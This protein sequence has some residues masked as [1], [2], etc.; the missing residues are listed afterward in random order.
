MLVCSWGRE[1]NTLLTS[2]LLNS[3]MDCVTMLLIF[4]FDFVGG[5]GKVS[6]GAVLFVVQDG[7]TAL[8]LACRKGV[9]KVV[10]LL[11]GK[12]ADVNLQDKVGDMRCNALICPTCQSSFPGEGRKFMKFLT[13][14]ACLLYS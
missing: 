11:L 6:C 12:G 1:S 3:F 5:C 4:F 14:V 13:C 9:K 2:M 7:T 8:M 10:D